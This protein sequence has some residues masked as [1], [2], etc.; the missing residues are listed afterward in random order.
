MLPLTTK[1]GFGDDFVSCKC[2]CVVLKL[3]QRLFMFSWHLYKKN[4][5]GKMVGLS[6]F[7]KRC[8]VKKF[9][10]PW[11]KLIRVKCKCFTR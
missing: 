1:D 5:T 9:E 3:T 6:R 11:P 8:C 4:F 10:E 7:S 2:T